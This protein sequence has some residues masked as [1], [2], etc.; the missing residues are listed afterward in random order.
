[1]TTLTSASDPLI[2]DADSHITEPADIWTSRLPSK[3]ADVAPRVEFSPITNHHHWRIGSRWLMPVGFNSQAGWTQFPPDVPW[4]YEECDPATYD[5]TDRLRKLDKFGVDIQLL[6]PNLIGFYA[7]DFME[8]GQGLAESCV[9]AYNDFLVEWSSADPRRLIPVA[10][11]PFWDLAASVR[12]MERC[13]SLGF[14]SVLFANKFEQIDLP[15]FVDPYWD[16]IYAAAQHLELPINFHI[17]FADRGISDDLSMDSLAR[18]R[19]SAE[20]KDQARLRAVRKSAHTEMTQCDMLGNLLLSGL[21]ER[22]PGLKLVSVETGFG[23]I[24]FYLEALDWQW[25]SQGATSLPLLPSEYFARQCYATFWFDRVSLPLLSAYPENFMF[26]TDFPHPIS[27]SPGPCAGTNLLPSEW[28]RESF[29]G[30]DPLVAT[31]ALSGNAARLY[32]L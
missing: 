26:S 4:E 24:P 23:H 21:C 30:I 13:A 18:R 19:E 25:K 32:G 6:Y 27:L 9:R 29:E 28:V 31:K 5:S 12:E 17:G 2:I 16:P 14:K 7:L 20:A 10:A 1:M 3:F 8:L 11:L 15:S 22:F